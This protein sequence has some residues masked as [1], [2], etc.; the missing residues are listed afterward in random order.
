VH[1]KVR[2]GGPVSFAVDTSTHRTTLIGVP[3]LAICE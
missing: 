3:E 1:V 2:H